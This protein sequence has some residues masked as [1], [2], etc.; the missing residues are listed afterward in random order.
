MVVLAASAIVSGAR[1]LVG[2]GSPD[3]VLVGAAVLVAD[4]A[5]V[6]TGVLVAVGSVVGA[7]VGT[8]VGVAVGA[9]VSTLSEIGVAE[10]PQAMAASRIDPNRILSNGFKRTHLGFTPRDL[11]AMRH[12]NA[13]TG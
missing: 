10:E 4:E 6:G 5:L 12:L 8:E 11:V 9:L 3:S 1:V 2:V 13:I 7:R